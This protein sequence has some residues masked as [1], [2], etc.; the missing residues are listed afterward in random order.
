MSPTFCEPF[1]LQYKAGYKFVGGG[2]HAQPSAARN[3]PRL[4]SMSET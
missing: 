2:V 3:L 4:R 1:M